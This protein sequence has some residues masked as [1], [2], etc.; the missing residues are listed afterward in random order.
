MA[1]AQ[2]RYPHLV[3]WAAA[4][5]RRMRTAGVGRARSGDHPA[6]SGNIV[7][8]SRLRGA[9][10]T[11]PGLPS[12]PAVPCLSP[13][14]SRPASGVQSFGVES[15]FSGDL[16][17]LVVVGELDMDTAPSLRDA[18]ALVQDKGPAT[19]VIDVSGLEFID[20]CGLHQLVLALKRQREV[21]GDVVLRSPRPNVLRVLEMVGLT[22]VFR[23]V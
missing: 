23:I 14:V 20:S 5:A 8:R 12:V 7:E 1:T 13:A 16:A 17:T 15:S 22:Q 3:V 19:L 21:G 18:L 9:G 10:S 4:E 6:G 2:D 11:T